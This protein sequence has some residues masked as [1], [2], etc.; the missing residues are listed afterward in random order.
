MDV[1]TYS[2]YNSSRGTKST[3]KVIYREMVLGLEPLNLEH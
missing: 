3:R 2:I 1:C